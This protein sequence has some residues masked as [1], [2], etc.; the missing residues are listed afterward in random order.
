MS[1]ARQERCACG[2]PLSLH[3]PVAECAGRPHFPERTAGEVPWREL[4]SRLEGEV[5]E[6][7]KRLE[8]AEIVGDVRGRALVN[9]RQMVAAG[10]EVSKCAGQAL[11]I[12]PTPA[13]DGADGPGPGFSGKASSST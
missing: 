10:S 3:R 2:V 8:Q 12:G 11:T 4:V 5:A 7:E 6:L 13:N 1:Q 9:I